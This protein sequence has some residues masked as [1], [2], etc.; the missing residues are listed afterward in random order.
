MGRGKHITRE[1][2]D[3][4]SVLQSSGAKQSEIAREI[5]RSR[6][7]ISKE[8]NKETSVFYR[9]KYIGSQSHRN[10]HKNWKE[11]HKRKRM[12]DPEM[13]EYAIEKIKL[14]WTPEQVAGRIFQDIG[15]K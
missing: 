2:R 13:Q 3:K 9:G 8:L 4:I 12:E 15:K 14:G 6:S 5:G 10:V 11:S 1:E 7:A